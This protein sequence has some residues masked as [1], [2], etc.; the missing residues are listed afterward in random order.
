MQSLDFIM[1][2]GARF[3]D[4]CNGTSN[5]V[6]QLIVNVLADL[7]SHQQPTIATSGFF[8]GETGEARPTASNIPG[9]RRISAQTVR[10]RL[11]ENGLRAKCPY[12]GTVLRRRY[13]LARNR[14]CNRVGGCDLQNWRWFWFS[15]EADSAEKRWPHMCIQTPE[16]EVR[17]EL[18]RWGRQFRRKKCDDVRC[19]ILRP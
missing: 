1:F 9:H 5:P 7:G 11:R 12:F 10:N 19:H 3:P 14:W 18:R 6:Q 15:D 17:T 4:S 2:T 16:L 13:R 8:T